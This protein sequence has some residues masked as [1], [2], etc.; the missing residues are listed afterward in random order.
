M[1]NATEIGSLNVLI[2][3]CSPVSAHMLSVAYGSIGFH[4]VVR[5]L[6]SRPG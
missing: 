3:V 6:Y 4:L 1:L 2:L 5:D